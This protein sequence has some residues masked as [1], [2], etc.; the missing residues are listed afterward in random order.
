MNQG[1]IS[2]RDD[3]DPGKQLEELVP[4]DLL[5]SEF[6]HGTG[7]EVATRG[8]AMFFRYYEEQGWPLS[9]LIEDTSFDLSAWRDFSQ[10]VHWRDFAQLLDNAS[11][12]LDDAR[13]VELG[14]RNVFEPWS[15][16]FIILART[17]Y[18]EPGPLFRRF[19][20][21]AIGVGTLVIRCIDHEVITD[22]DEGIEI[23]QVMWRGFAAS[24]PYRAFSLGILSGI[25]EALYLPRPEFEMETD[26][27]DVIYRFRYARGIA[28]IARLRRRLFRLMA[29]WRIAP[30]IN[31]A[32]VML[33]QRFR[34][35]TNEIIRRE[36]AET[37]LREN[38]RRFRALVEHG[39]DLVVILTEDLEPTYLSPFLMRE[40]GIGETADAQFQPGTRVQL[41]ALIDRVRESH[42]QPMRCQITTEFEG[43]H[44]ELEGYVTNHTNTPAIEGYVFKLRDRTEQ[45]RLQQQ[46][47]RTA[48][49]DAVGRL[50]AGVAHDFNNYL[51][52]IHSNVDL[53]TLDPADAEGALRNIRR[54]VDG[55]SGLVEALLTVGRDSAFNPTNLEVNTWLRQLEG[56]LST[57]AGGN[58]I[59][60]AYAERD[61]AITADPMQLEQVLINLVI[62]AEDAL[63]DNPGTID[64]RTAA[65]DDTVVMTVSDTGSGIEPSLLSSIFEPFFTTKGDAGNGLGLSMV[66]AIVERH[67]GTI[68][69]TSPD[70]GGTSF[71][72]RL[73]LASDPVGA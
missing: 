11:R 66:L 5:S 65:A 58:D 47:D 10:R 70:E 23:R 38:E 12:R 3:G 2:K 15:L 39:E 56:I 35:L 37:A 18:D 4:A 16:P 31:R 1:K 8:A 6:L 22:T 52:L 67:G 72:I 64:I 43:R 20:E 69:A 49:M 9:E 53:A 25:P 30:E 26:G 54:S 13:L 57:A 62:N 59:R 42:G 44:L 33:Q 55:A 63:R 14:H 51:Q 71:E 60:F 46:V 29:S 50:A 7:Y 68:E 27:D 36:N 40:L 41:R 21:P 61:L 45:N 28:S 73:P 19:V 32:Y 24:G 34:D 17:L 48:R